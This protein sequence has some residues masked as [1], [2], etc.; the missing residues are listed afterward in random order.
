MDRFS[1]LPDEILD[2]ISGEVQEPRSLFYMSLVS[3]NCYHVFS[4]R[5]YE[6]VKSG[7][8]QIDTLALLENE[9]IPLTSPHPASFVKTLELE[10]FPLDPEWDVEEKEWQEQETIRE[11]LFKRQAD[12]ALNNV[13]KYAIL[14]RLSL[15]FPKIHLHKGLGKLNSIKLGHLRHLAVRCLILEHQSLDIFESLCR[16]S[17]TLNHLE[18]HWDE[19][20]D[21]PEAVARLLEVI[22]KACSNLQ[23]IRMST[24][25]YPESYEPVQRVLDDPNFTFPLLDNCHCNDF[26]QCN[27]LKFLERHPKIEKLQVSNVN[28]GDPEDEELDL[29][30]G[31]AN[32]KTLRQL[33]LTDYSM[34]TMSL[35]LLASVTKACPKLT[36]F[37]CALG[38]EKSMAS[39]C[40]TFPDL[41]YSTIF[42]N[43]PNLEHLRLQFRHASDPEADMFQNSYFQVLA[44]RHPL[45]TMQ[46]DILVICAQRAQWKCFY[47]MKDNNRIIPAP[48]LDA[49]RFDW[50]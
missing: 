47:F 35:V 34:N 11:N 4:R 45:K 49:N 48:K 14:R 40:P 13:A 36:H 19:W 32:A 43:L 26:M 27:A 37:K 17:R 24:S 33:D 39:R 3:K 41:I 38:N 30:N 25:F 1:A 42:R 28:I 23:G 29:V 20:N 22:P 15:R 10:F 5:L 8:K 31:L 12:S 7:D 16:S 18:L 46:I 44:S 6:S 21:S 9:R 2:L 50:F